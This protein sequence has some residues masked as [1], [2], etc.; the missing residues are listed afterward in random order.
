MTS[1]RI[2]LAAIGAFVLVALTSLIY[3]LAVLAGRTG[4]TDDYYTLYTNVA[5]LK[6]G[7]QVFYEGYLVGQVTSVTP[8]T[9]QARVQ[10]R[11]GMAITAGWKIPEDSVARSGSSG[12][13]APQTIS[14]AAGKSETALKPGALITP[15]LSVDLFSTVT[16]AAGSFDRLASGGLMPLF[17]NLDRQ[18]TAVGGLLDG[19]VRKLVGN[20][21]IVAAA[22]AQD[23][24]LVLRNARNASSGLANVTQQLQS[25]LTPARIASLDRIIGNADLATASLAR[26]SASLER[27]SGDGEEDLK[28]A[29]RELRLTSESLSRHS[30]S[31]AQNLDAASRN[32]QE[33]SR[34]LKQNP[35]LLIR[36]TPGTDAIAP[37]SGK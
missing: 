32:L 31:I 16:G 23:L 35:G 25:V 27:L 9:E 22:A 7:S 3:V 12:L 20:A 28:V 13:L 5:G 11:V 26:T 19:D 34:K 8:M 18:I 10:F 37:E 29:L 33:L 14:I 21:N 1:T 24:P 4:S 17:E 15:G 30:E 2:N 6:Y 36:N